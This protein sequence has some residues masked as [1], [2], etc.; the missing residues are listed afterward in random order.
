MTTSRLQ[1]RRTNWR[2]IVFDVLL[3]ILGIF[4]FCAAMSAIGWIGYAHAQGVGSAIGSADAPAPVLVAPIAT[5]PDIGG[6]LGFLT[7][8]K[9]LAAVGAG[10]VLV[11][12]V[13]RNYL[14][15]NVAWFQTQVGGYALGWGVTTILYVA[16]ALQSGQTIAWLSLLGTAAAAGLAA[17]GALDHFRDVISAMNKPIVAAPIVKAGLVVTLVIGFVAGGFALTSCGATGSQIQQ[18]G[19]AC[20]GKQV[21]TSLLEQVAVDLFTKNFGDLE[22]LAAQNGIAFVNCL[23]TTAIAAHST[24]QTGSGVT[25][26]A[27]S[28][29][30]VNGGEWLKEH[31]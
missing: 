22:S 12:G 6:L 26:S 20:A 25:V 30:V 18:N 14:L 27:P 31:P 28:P 9:Y 15:K 7:S 1:T 3:V 21:S 24:P 16:T 10:L 11:I 2:K 4:A 5:T 13:I 23:V 19:L 17:S 29:I 8:G